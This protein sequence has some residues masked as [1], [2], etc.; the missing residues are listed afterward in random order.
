MD[1]GDAPEATLGAIGLWRL[2]GLAP[3][4]G[5][6]GWMVLAEHQGRG[7]ATEAARRLIALARAIPE[8]RFVHAFP[9]VTNTA[10]NAIA[11]KLGMQF[12]GDFDNDGFAGA[13]RCNNWRLDL[14]ASDG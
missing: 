2:D 1:V 13:L 12:L 6:M 9:A 4:T 14:R 7:R 8:V 11:R 5:E 10:S 3:Q